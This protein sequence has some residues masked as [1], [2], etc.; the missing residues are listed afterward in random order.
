M[1]ERLSGIPSVSKYLH[2][3]GWKV[4]KRTLYQHRKEGRLRPKEDG[5]FEMKD[6]DKYARLH[7]KKLDGLRPSDKIEAIQ[8][9]KL[10][11]EMRK[12]KAQADHYELKTEI[13]KGKYIE[14]ARHESDLAARSTIFK[15]DLTNFYH[16]EVEK[17]IKLVNGDLEKAPELLQY[18]LTNLDNSLARYSMDREFTVEIPIALLS[19]LDGSTTCMESDEDVRDNEIDTD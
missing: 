11:N 16:S 18:M 5:T 6:V 14:Y 2:T 19:E 10:L 15:T 8:E 9:K 1:K 17:I 13:M 12:A 4:A 3:K 7:L